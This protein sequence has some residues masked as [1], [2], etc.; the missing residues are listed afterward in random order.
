M[1]TPFINALSEMPMYAKFLQE[2]LSKKWKIDEHEI[3]ALGEKCSALVLNR[4]LANLKDPSN[5]S[6]PYL[7]RNVSINRALSD[8]RSTV[9]LLPYYIFKRL[10]L[11]GLRP[12]TVS[13]QLADC[14]VKCPLGILDEILI[15][16]GIFMCL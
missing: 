7:I 10:D 4:L 6:I 15:K 11:M 5:F 9:S 2:I 13:Y 3:I 8:L 12:T 16:V 1:R 14:S